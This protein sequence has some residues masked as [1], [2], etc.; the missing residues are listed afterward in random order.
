MILI[1]PPIIKKKSNAAPLKRFRGVLRLMPICILASF[2]LMS[3]DLYAYVMESGNYRMQSD[4]LNVSGGHWDSSNYIFEDTTGEIA[5]GPSAS[6]SYKLKAGYQQMQEVYISISSPS[7]V[8]MAPAF[9]GITGG[10]A[11]GSAMWTI[12]TDSPSGFNMK[13]KASTDPAMKQDDTYFFNDY[14]PS[15]A[16]SPDYDW[17]S[18]GA[19]VAEFGFTI[20][21]ET[22][23]DTASLFTDNNADSCDVGGNTNTPDKCWFDFNGTSNIDVVYRTTRTDSDGENE[24]VKFR[25]ESSAKFLKEGY[26]DAYI[27]AT[28]VPN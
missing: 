3:A 25:A 17:N 14:S 4:S 2:F 10:L 27:I 15:A 26:Y 19:S 11:S 5:S 6:P 20:E 21:P 12:I 18:P 28:V 13:V 8:L 7:D 9:G 16:G 24:T 23:A 22:A 1:L